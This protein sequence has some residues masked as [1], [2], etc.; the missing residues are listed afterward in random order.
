MHMC[1]EYEI[2]EKKMFEARDREE[3]LNTL[4]MTKDSKRK[5]RKAITEFELVLRER[6]KNMPDEEDYEAY[7]DRLITEGK[8]ENTAKST[9][10]RV[11]KYYAWLKASK[12][13]GINSGMGVARKANKHRF[14]LLLSPYLHEQLEL[15][16]QY[17]RCSITEILIL[18]CEK[19]VSERAEDIEYM[20][21]INRG[22]DERNAQRKV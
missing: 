18:L 21:K 2:G 1:K 7:Y 14:N 17:E 11:R 9:L 19:C 6:N 10:Q 4:N 12:A 22:I 8:Q 16:S 15:L 3:Y 20:K 13:T 5:Y